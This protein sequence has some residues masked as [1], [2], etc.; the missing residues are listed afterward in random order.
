MQIQMFRCNYA[1]PIYFTVASITAKETIRIY[2]GILKTVKIMFG[3]VLS[4]ATKVTAR[5]S[6][7]NCLSVF[8]QK[9]VLQT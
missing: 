3:R 2:G 6:N 7:L 4:D 9:T 8:N 5:K 1:N